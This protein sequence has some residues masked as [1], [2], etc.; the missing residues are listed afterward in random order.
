MIAMR[1]MEVPSDQIVDMVTVRHRF[2]TATWTMYMARFVSAALMLRRA[3]IRIRRVDF[4]RVFVDMV[5]MRMMQMAVV[6]IVDVVTVFDGGMPT[7]LTML[8]IMVGVMR[9]GAGAHEHSL[10][11]WQWA[12][13]AACASTLSSSARTW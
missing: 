8:V 2:M 11:E 1:V 10:K 9:L 7:I 12:Y 5:A 6:Q 3:A 13:S 4:Q